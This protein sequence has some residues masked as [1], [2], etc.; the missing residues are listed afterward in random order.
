MT[1]TCA[2]R[3]GVASVRV[4][5]AGLGSPFMGKKIAGAKQTLLDGAHPRP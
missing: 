5:S 4:V 3:W 1:V 2:L